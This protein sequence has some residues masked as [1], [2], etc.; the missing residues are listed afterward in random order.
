MSAIDWRE[1]FESVSLV[2]AMLR[3]ESNFGALDFP[4]RDQYR[5]A[6]EE[7]ARGSNSSEIEVTRLALFG[8]QAGGKRRAGRS[9]GS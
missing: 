6:V 1:L 5:R 2:D 8:H 9:L 7:L 4:T 3:A